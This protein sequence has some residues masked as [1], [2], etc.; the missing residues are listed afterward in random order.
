VIRNG[1]PLER[2]EPSR[3]LGARESLR[4]SL[5]VGPQD[6]LVFL[7]A[8]LRSGKGHDVLLAA[9]PL[10]RERVPRVCFALAGCGELE[11]EVRRGAA[12]LGSGV[13]L[14]GHRRD[15]PEL[16]AAS[17]L[18][19]LPTLSEALPTVAMEAAA[20]GRAMVAS[21]VGGVPEV[22]ED[23]ITGTLVPPGDVRA[24][25][26]GVAALLLHPEVRISMGEAAR[27][28]ALEEFGLE[29]QARTT[30]QFW[31]EVVEEGATS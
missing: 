26:E 27:R 4:A 12:A 20:A 18:V 2:F 14:L 16:L 6:P 28:R 29:A 31:R 23:Q 15:I 10:I 30:L 21:R 17:D 24:L 25:A 3:I 19:V 5:G 13:R 9:A 8:V 7:P 11:A 1:I 22:V